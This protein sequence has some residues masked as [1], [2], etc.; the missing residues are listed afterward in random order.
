MVII[1]I[2]LFLSFYKNNT[3]DNLNNNY[4]NT[5]AIKNTNI[6][7]ISITDD[8]ILML[9]KNG[10]LYLY[11]QYH[12]VGIGIGPESY[13][14]P[15]KIASNVKYFDDYGRLV[16]VKNDDTA[17][18]I[19]TDIDGWG[20]VKE[21]ELLTSNVKKI[22]S[23]NFCFFILD[24][25]NNYIVKAPLENITA[26]SW[27][28][29]PKELDGDFSNITNN[30][31]D[32]YSDGLSANGY[33]TDNND[34]YI[35]YRYDI[36]Y[37]K[38]LSNVNKIVG[39]RIITN[40]GIVYYLDYVDENG[41]EFVKSDDNIEDVY[42]TEF[43]YIYKTSDNE[44]FY[45]NDIYKLEY[46]DIKVPYYYNDSKFVYL[47]NNNRIVLSG[48]VDTYELKVSIDSMKQIYDFVK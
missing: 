9:E 5:E 38:V 28:A 16:I 36:G 32:I 31:K 29:L 33:L 17:Y 21:F 22:T 35:S 19:G 48:E 37:K 15:T 26:K 44:F 27:C 8:Y 43:G 45:R 46:N 6:M 47:N 12:A 41:G 40:E 13:E 10:D 2:L 4:G 1:S 3:N 34:L 42:E 7:Q 23:T 24:K 20:T 30:V 18:Y 39:N 11:G 25:D 14:K